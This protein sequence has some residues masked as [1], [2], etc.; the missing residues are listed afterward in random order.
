MPDGSLGSPLLNRGNTSRDGTLAGLR[1]GR[2]A[3]SNPAN[4]FERTRADAFDDG[5][6]TLAEAMADLPPLATSLTRD[7]SRSA[8]AWN[9][10]PDLGFDRSINPYRGCEHGC[11]YCYARPSHAWIGLSPGLDFE[12]RLQFKPEVASLLEKELSKPGYTPRPIALGANT[13]PYQPVERTLGL[14]RQVLE[15]LDRFNHPVTVVTKSAGVLRDLDILTRM[16]SRNLVQ[17]CLSVTTLDHRLARIMEPRAATPLRRLAAM[18][19]L[20]RAGIPV[21]VLAAP[22]I[23]GVNDAEL[24]K[25]LE[26][27]HAHGARA[28]GY[29]LLRLPLEIRQMFEDWLNAHM[30]DRAARVLALVR[31]TRAGKTYD[32][33]FGT[34]QT[35]TGPYADMLARRFAVAMKRL[36]LDGARENGSLDCSAFAVPRAEARQLELL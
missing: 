30:P 28:A 10:S 3:V 31:E 4:R 18:L 7:A 5:W 1:R 19:E 12:S 6:G 25:I 13:D 9:D 21:G 17:V 23:P 35:G 11:I 15:V 2:G 22:M 27:A 24:E 26:A 29:V 8:L 32:S 34:R 36:G 16:A 14:T 33:R 20:H